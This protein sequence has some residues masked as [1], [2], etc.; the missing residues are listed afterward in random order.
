LTVV[1]AEAGVDALNTATP[2]APSVTVAARPIP[3][4][5]LLLT[6]FTSF[7]PI[8]TG[9]LAIAIAIVREEVVASLDL[10]RQTLDLWRQS[11]ELT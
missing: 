5:S 2:A 1:V 4:I 11:R 8:L 3:P 7:S 6:V 9:R 10:Q